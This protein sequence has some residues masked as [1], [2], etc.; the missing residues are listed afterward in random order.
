LIARHREWFEKHMPNCLRNA[1]GQIW[2]ERA[3][4]ARTT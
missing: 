1:G 4:A 3:I 2:I